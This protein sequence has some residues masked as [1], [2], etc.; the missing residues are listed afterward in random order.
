L[1][2]R[3]AES[4]ESLQKAEKKRNPPC[5]VD[6]SRL[7]ITRKS[8]HRGLHHPS[9]RGGVPSA[10]GAQKHEFHVIKNQIREAD[11]SGLTYRSK[12]ETR[13]DVKK[14]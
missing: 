6:R 14:N 2:R 11:E 9:E 3:R 8:R 1:D 13:K 10:G 4:R 12:I 7:N 5:P